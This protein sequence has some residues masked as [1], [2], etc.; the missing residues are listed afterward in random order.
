MGLGGAF[1]AIV[2]GSLTSVMIEQNSKEDETKNKLKAIEVF[3]EDQK[4]KQMN[5]LKSL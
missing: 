5:K 2:V 1:Y 3:F 4:T